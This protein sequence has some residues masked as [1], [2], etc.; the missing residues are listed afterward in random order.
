MQTVVPA[1]A[2][3]TTVS[4]PG[5]ST[6]GEPLPS[7]GSQR[8]RSPSTASG[9]ARVKVALPPS[10][11]AVTSG[12]GTATPATALPDSPSASSAPGAFGPSPPP[13]STAAAMAAPTTA[14]DATEIQTAAP[15]RRRAGACSRCGSSSVVRSCAS[16]PA[17][18]SPRSTV[19]SSTADSAERPSADGAK[20]RVCAATAG[21]SRMRVA[22]T[23]A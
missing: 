23:W 21:I 14:T 22:S 12:A 18:T 17:R 6:E 11:S 16:V 20:R 13:S 1:G 4:C 3:T 2:S 7:A 10:T 8:N 9:F 15:D 5:S 19:P